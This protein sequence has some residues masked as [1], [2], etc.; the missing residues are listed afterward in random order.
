MQI[1]NHE[2]IVATSAS[3]AAEPGARSRDG[4]AAFRYRNYRLFW[5]GQSVSVTGTWMQ[6]LAQSW[7]V[8]DTLDASAFELGLVNALQFAPVLLFGILGG[9]VADRFPKRN[10]LVLTQST[11]ALLATVLTVLV[12]TG[13]VEFWHVLALAACFGLTN[14][15]DMPSRQAFVSEMV[16][17]EAIVN[18]IALNAALFNSGRILGPAI[19]GACLALF[20][21]AVCFGINAISYLGVIAGLL[22]MRVAPRTHIV[23]GSPL[24]RL[25]EGLTYVRHTPEILRP[26][27]LIGCVGVFGMNFSV[28]LPLLAKEDFGAG[29]GTFG[30]LFASNGAGSL[31]GALTLAFSGMQPSRPRMLATAIGLGVV[32]LIL[33]FLV[34]IPVPVLAGMS[35]LVLTGFCASMTMATGNTLVQ[36][37][38]GDALRGRVMAVYMTVFAGTV[39]IGALISGTIADRFSGVVSLGTGAVITLVA[40]AILAITQRES[41]DTTTQPVSGTLRSS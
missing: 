23:S 16:G 31:I 3:D 32:E 27:I 11:F 34:A 8:V 40:A 6:S 25:R 1:R 29:A 20:G 37:T 36:T 22:M 14:A 2:R 33:A 26:I 4:F 10:L 30:L 21:P 17:K 15:F 38:A 39:P 12:A 41:P 7:L 28:W 19:A 24:E 35:L 18:A 13:M 5:F 9:V